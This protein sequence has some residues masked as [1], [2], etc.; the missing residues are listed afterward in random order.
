[1][2]RCDQNSRHRLCPS[3]FKSIARPSWLQKVLG[4]GNLST[5]EKWWLYQG[6]TPP[7]AQ[8]PLV[9]G[10]YSYLS[11]EFGMANRTGLSARTC[12]RKSP[13]KN[14]QAPHYL[15]GEV[16]AVTLHQACSLKTNLPVTS[17][18]LPHLSYYAEPS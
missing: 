17:A 16:P 12:S 1:M 11:N 4:G 8:L 7:S 5:L 9:W 14:T 10:P 3:L 13:H 6:D 15:G 18:C 2:K